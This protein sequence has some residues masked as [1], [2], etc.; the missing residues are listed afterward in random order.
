MS[1][2]ASVFLIKITNDFSSEEFL[3]LRDEIINRFISYIDPNTRPSTGYN[4]SYFTKYYIG[5]LTSLV[6]EMKNAESFK[7]ISIIFKD[8]MKALDDSSN[9]YMFIDSLYANDGAEDFGFILYDV[10]S[11][12]SNIKLESMLKV[13]Y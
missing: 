7:D 12:N 1:S 10:F 5:R 13:H 4:E 3:L 11:C 8:H 2:Y 6:T 9:Q